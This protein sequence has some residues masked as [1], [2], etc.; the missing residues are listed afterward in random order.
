[1]KNNA[2]RE[3]SE[4]EKE[5]GVTSANKAKKSKVRQEGYGEND[6]QEL[7][8]GRRVSGRD[9]QWEDIKR[10]RVRGST[11]NEDKSRQRTLKRQ[12]FGKAL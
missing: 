9:T 5:K 3:A 10:R 4:S 2:V 7:A 1:M 11:A 8:K 6:K 12:H